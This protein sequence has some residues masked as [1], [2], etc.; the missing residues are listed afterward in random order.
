MAATP[1]TETTRST[2]T[3]DVRTGSTAEEASSELPDIAD[4]KRSLD[5]RELPG[6]T[7]TIEPY[8][9]VLAD[10]ALEAAG[11]DSGERGKQCVPA[12]AGTRSHRE[13]PANGSGG[14][15][16]GIRRG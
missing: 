9:S 1:S 6:A 15:T 4:L 10:Y 8:Q 5:G 14:P 13:P 7:I 3:D 12:R 11:D 2:E 16:Y